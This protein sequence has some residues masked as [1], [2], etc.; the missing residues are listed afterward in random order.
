MLCDNPEVGSSQ[1]YA[2]L[3]LLG[4][5]TSLLKILLTVKNQL[6]RATFSVRNSSGWDFPFSPCGRMILKMMVAGRRTCH[7]TRETESL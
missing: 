6:V 5:S 2:V 3:V 1:Y 7:V 4:I